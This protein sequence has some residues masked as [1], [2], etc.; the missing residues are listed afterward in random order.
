M[1]N[2]NDKDIRDYLVDALLMGTRVVPAIGGAVLGGGSTFGLGALAGGAAGG[3][4]GESLA[5]EIERYLGRREALDP[6]TI[7]LTGALGAIPMG[8]VAQV[9]RL[10]R[11]AREAAKG[12]VIG[13]GS[14]IAFQATEQDTLRP[15][16][17]LGRTLLST[18]N[19]SQLFAV[20]F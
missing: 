5:Q 9:G 16:L 7:A 6:K 8:R 10:G 13:A 11:M 17:D 15:Q 2:P 14:D 1:P 19:L 20:M 12:G 18:G 3:A 4:L